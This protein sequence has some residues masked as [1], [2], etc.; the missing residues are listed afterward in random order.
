MTDLDGPVPSEVTANAR[1]AVVV[2]HAHGDNLPALREWVPEFTGELAGSW[3]GAPGDGLL[4]VGGFTDG[5]RAAYLAEH[6]GAT[7][8]LLWGFDFARVEESDPAARDRKLAKLR[9]A[10]DDLAL[11]ARASRVGLTEWRRDGSRR[12]FQGTVPDRSTQ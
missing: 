7:S 12:P 10:N 8:I 9:W 5:E 11:L 3:S 1:G 6:C 2:V 4:D